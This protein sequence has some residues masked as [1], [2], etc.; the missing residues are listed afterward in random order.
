MFINVLDVAPER[1]VMFDS[2][3]NK[4][5][6]VFR[7]F[8][9]SIKHPIQFRF[10][11]MKSMFPMSVTKRFIFSPHENSHFQEV[12]YFLHKMCRNL[13]RRNMELEDSKLSKTKIFI[14]L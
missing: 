7:E 10:K 13:M 4:A 11:E 14:P 8:R 3:T 5:F 6:E 1:S 12:R 2:P 9:R